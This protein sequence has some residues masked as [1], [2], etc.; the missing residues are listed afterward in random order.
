MRKVWVAVALLGTL[1][2]CGSGGEGTSGSPN[3]NVEALPRPA[4]TGT[5]A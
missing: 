2:A 3:E 1:V 4:E 5:P